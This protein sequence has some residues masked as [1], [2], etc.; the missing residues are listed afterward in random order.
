MSGL[1]TG[2]WTLEQARE[3]RWYKP[4]MQCALIR[5]RLNE[6]TVWDGSDL[7]EVL[8]CKLNVV[9]GKEG[10]VVVLAATEMCV[11]CHRPARERYP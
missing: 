4:D 1:D 6:L 11:N 10:E 5:A 7:A 8:D 3:H 9:I 2:V